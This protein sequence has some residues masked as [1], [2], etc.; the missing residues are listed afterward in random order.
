MPKL[1]QPSV[2]CPMCQYAND[3]NFSFCQACG[4]QRK[5]VVVKR[6][7]ALRFSVDEKAIDLR[8]RSLEQSRADTRYGKQKSALESEF[9]EFLSR[10][11]VPKSVST[12]LPQDVIS[13]LVW[14]DQGGRTVVH[15]PTCLFIDKRHPAS[16]ECPKRLAHGTVDSLIGKLRAIFAENGRGTEWHSLLGLGNPAADRSVKAYLASVREEQLRVHITPKQAEPVLV[17]DLET[18]A[19]HIQGKLASCSRFNPLQLF[20]LAR[21]QAVFKALFFSADR[22]ADLLGV[23]S[24]TILRF[25][26]DSG[27][28]FNQVW[29]K[30]LRS[31]DSNV[32]ALK[33]GSNKH[34]CPVRGL[35]T[36][37]K[38]SRDI[39]IDISRGFLF[40]SVS[41]S[42]GITPRAL[43]PGAVQA[44]LDMY[45][46]ELEGCLSAKRFTL[47]GF[48]SGAAISMALSGVRLEHIMDHVGWK[49]SRTAL[50][51]IKLDRVMNPEGA[52]A[53]LA[54][55][56]SDLGK[57]YKEINALKDFVPA[58]T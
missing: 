30:S 37:F 22:A 24:H 18:L 23:L 58:F 32:F 2:A 1:F 31:G 21:D 7:S 53:R 13:F 12:A 49:S 11:S 45:C 57:K 42:G 34:T 46:K 41:K 3:E 48:R 50:H 55:A 54:N 44:R 27:F 40:R 33:R 5:E 35:E 26:D 10:L 15:K 36:Y 16:C 28:L 20:L 14:K 47:H 25:P 51:Y 56:E 17:S 4:Y 52:A 29:S 38:I 8:V 19:R 39:K 6:T 43:E 9:C